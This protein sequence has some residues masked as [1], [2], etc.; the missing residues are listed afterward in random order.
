MVLF[1][2]GQTLMVEHNFNALDGDRAVLARAADPN[3]VTAEELAAF[4]AELT[5]E[6]RQYGPEGEKHYRFEVHG[7][8]F[9]RYL[10]EYLGIDLGM[11][12]L[13]TEEI[14]WDAAAPGRP[15]DGMPELLAFL[16]AHGIRTGVVS[17]ISFSGEA[18]ERRLMRGFPEHRFDFILASSEYVFR[19]PGRR[20]FELALRKAG[21]PPEKVWHCGDNPY[22][23][24]EGAYAA[25]IFPVWYTGNLL[26]ARREPTVPCLEVTRWEQLLEILRETIGERTKGQ[27]AEF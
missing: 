14:F 12:M 19:K 24:V 8:P 11:G 15:A 13:E 20:I 9:Q 10:Y 3:G 6:Y 25:G 16:R 21:L 2:Y 18:L 17:N 1:D 5:A 7:H 22:C 27:H 23:D 4:S 26:R